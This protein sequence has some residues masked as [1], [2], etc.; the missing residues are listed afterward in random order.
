MPSDETVPE[1]ITI[2]P[3]QPAPGRLWIPA[4]GDELQALFQQLGLGDQEVQQLSDESVSIL[5]RCVPPTDPDRASTGLVLGYVQSGKTRSMTAV[6][7]LA[8]D[9][10][11][12]L[13]IILGGTTTSLVGQSSG[14]FEDDLRI[15]SRRDRA[16]AMFPNPTPVAHRQMMQDTL[17]RWNPPPIPGLGRQTL[18]I[19][20]MKQGDHLDHLIAILESL[21]LAGVPAIIFDD[22]ADQAG[23]N[24]QVRRN[25][26]SPTYDRLLRLRAALPHHTYLEYTAT[27]QAPLL[28]NLVDQLSPDFVDILTPGQDYTGVQQIFVDNPGLVRVIPPADIPTQQVPLAGPPAS[29]HRAMRLF[30]LGVASGLIRENGLGHRSMLVHPSSQRLDHL[31][32]HRWVQDAR[33]LWAD[34]LDRPVADPDR[35]DLLEDFHASWRDL[36]GTVV[37]VPSFTEIEAVLGPAIRATKVWEVNTRTGPTPTIPWN[38]DYSHILVGGQAMDRG[39]TVEGLVVTY[40]PRGAG[41][42]NADTIQQRARFLGYKQGILGYVRVFLETDVA[43]AYRAYVDHEE[44]VRASLIQHRDS[45]STLDTW[46]RQMVLDMALRPTRGNV[47]DIPYRMTTYDDAWFRPKSPHLP[48]AVIQ[49]NQTVAQNFLGTLTLGPDAGHPQRTTEQRHRVATRV[50]LSTVY[51]GLLS[52]LRHGPP[53]SDEFTAVLVQ[54]ERYL[55]EHADA[56]ASVYHMAAGTRR[57]RGLD[58][59]DKILNLFQGKNPQRGPV[60]YPG[61]AHIRGDAGL[62][63]QIHNL[64]LRDDAGQVVAQDAA[65]IAVWVPSEMAVGV[66]IQNQGI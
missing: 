18:L 23:L 48:P 53:D 52:Q 24:N 12:R 45:G 42:G 60:I 31:Q 47:I 43:D 57:V 65:A 59:G 28:I 64:E 20:V 38:I 9:N 44:H 51:N 54:V 58:S 50:P 35:A 26:R 62:S 6:A 63:V 39:F 46:K 3:A 29:L 19:P 41:V 37:D 7:A 5:S 66:L 14:R 25:L 36:S 2:D 4:V 32:Y 17:Q 13:I 34:L 55:L 22:E 8:R 61:D 30:F 56:V 11:Y 10:G 21:N 27:P 49:A 40:M 33:L 1:T 16:W 15:Q